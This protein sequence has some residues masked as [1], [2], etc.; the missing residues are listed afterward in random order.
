MFENFRWTSID[1]VCLGW[2]DAVVLYHKH[3]TVWF[4]ISGTSFL[5]SYWSVLNVNINQVLGFVIFCSQFLI[6]KH[7]VVW[8]LA[9]PREIYCVELSYICKVWAKMN[10][11]GFKNTTLL[12]FP[13]SVFWA[14]SSRGV[15]V[16]YWQTIHGIIEGRG[17]KS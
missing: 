2:R 6:A 8:C 14:T 4:V 16:K 15:E 7:R 10:S 17:K 9:V 11:I 1:L 12:F 13:S 5:K 3:G